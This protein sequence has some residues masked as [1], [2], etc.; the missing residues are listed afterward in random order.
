MLDIDEKS[1]IDMFLLLHSG[2]VGRASANK[3]L[4]DC[5]SSWALCGDPHKDISNLVTHEVGVARR[6]FDFPKAGMNDAWNWD[7]MRLSDETR[8]P[9]RRDVVPQQGEHWTLAKDL[10]D[11]PMPPP[12]C[13]NRQ[14][15]HWDR[16][17]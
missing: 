2:E 12:C 17:S 16:P 9:F 4:W 1:M 3:L 10:G 15:V 8:E 13:F 6:V 5:L 11:A 7:H 14:Q